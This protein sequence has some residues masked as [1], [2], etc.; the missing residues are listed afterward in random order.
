MPAYEAHKP[1]ERAS[2]LAPPHVLGYVKANNALEEDAGTSK[3]VGDGT[4]MEIDLPPIARALYDLTILLEVRANGLPHLYH[5]GRMLV[6]AAISIR[7][8]GR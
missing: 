2:H 4:Y 5:S 3:Q 6:S 1:E 8:Y 7:R